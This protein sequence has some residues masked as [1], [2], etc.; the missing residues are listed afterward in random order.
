MEKIKIII[1]KENV[2]ESIYGRIDKIEDRII[3]LRYRNLEITQ[4]RTT[5]KE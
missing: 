5:T 3:E 1:K 4:R 2:I